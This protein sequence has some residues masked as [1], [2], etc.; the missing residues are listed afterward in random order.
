MQGYVN[1][2]ISQHHQNRLDRT[3]NLL[4]LETAMKSLT[5]TGVAFGITVLRAGWDR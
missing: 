1:N 2:F 3:K 4:G 5:G